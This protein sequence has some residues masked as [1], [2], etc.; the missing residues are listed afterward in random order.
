MTTANT[1][2]RIAILSDTHGLLR[3][4]VV[5]RIQ[6]V[7]H[8]LHAG[9]VGDPAILDTLGSIAPLTAIRGNVDTSGRC[10]SLPATEMVEIG[11]RTFYL[12]HS[13]ADLDISP[14]AARV[15]VVVSG[16][17]HKPGHETRNGVLYLNPGSVGPRRFRLP[18]A[19]AFLKIEN[20]KLTAEPVTFDL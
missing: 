2:I 6:G 4:E 18:I 11:G 20:G 19:M 3:P 9:D 5:E 14:T 15:Q 17:S 10:G 12:V 16:H 13:I 1:N 7:D 8:I